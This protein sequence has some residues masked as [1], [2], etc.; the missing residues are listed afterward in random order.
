MTAACH[1]AAMSFRERAD[2]AILPVLDL[3]PPI[4][5]TGD[6]PAAR[7]VIDAARRE[8]IAALPDIPEVRTRD[9]HVPGAAGDPDVLV[10]IYEPVEGGHSGAALAY[11]HGG[12]MVLMSVDDTDFHCKRIVRDVGCLVVSVEYRLAPEHPYP[13]ALHDCYAALAW[14]H[15][16]AGDLGVDRGRI[17]VGGLSAGGGLAAGVALLARDRGEVPLCFQWL[18][19]PM[20]D[21]RNETPSS[22]EITDPNVWNRASNEAAW[23]AYLGARAGG[24]VPLH[25]APARA[26]VDDLRGLPPAY[27][28][29]G[30]LDLFRDEDIAYA[31]RLLQAGVPTELHVTPGAFHASEMYG[32]DADTSRRIERARTEALRRA[33]GRVG[34]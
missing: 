33:L 29:V 25:A 7:R 34:G 15:D 11:I 14:L 27:V 12:G 2:Q 5:L 28:D 26:G 21:D 8:L 30:E 6:I 1:D 9:V 19:Y 3:V 23:A 17:G 22:H 4:D 18:V 10:R 32:P 31:Q 16:H 24:A 13:A 20:L